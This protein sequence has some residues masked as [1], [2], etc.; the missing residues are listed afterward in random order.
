MAER[1]QHDPLYCCEHCCAICRDQ[2]RMGAIRP[3]RPEELE[4]LKEMWRG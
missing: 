4:R 2:V 3:L 1:C